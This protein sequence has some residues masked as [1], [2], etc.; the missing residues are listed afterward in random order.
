MVI[1]ETGQKWISDALMSP[2]LKDS[3]SV[4]V[5]ALVH[6]PIRAE[7]DESNAVSN[8]MTTETREQLSLL[9]L[10]D[11]NLHEALRR[12]GQDPAALSADKSQVTLAFH[13]NIITAYSKLQS[14]QG[15]LQ[16]AVTA[17]EGAEYQ[18]KLL[19][20]TVVKSEVRDLEDI[21]AGALEVDTPTDK[22]YSA[23][24]ETNSGNLPRRTSTCPRTQSG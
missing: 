15:D 9:P 21:R 20:E 17:A 14:L 16:Q 12:S 19:P 2:E 22:C 5:S 4:D 11:E 13:P 7:E 3:N 18:P 6:A 24:I 10:D 8:I 23:S 1:T